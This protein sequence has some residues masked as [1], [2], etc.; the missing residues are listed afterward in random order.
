LTTPPSQPSPRRKHLPWVTQATTMASDTTASGSLVYERR[1]AHV[2]KY[3]WPGNQLNVW[4]LVMLIASSLI[5]GV[6]AT[7]IQIQQQLLLA[8][9]W[10][11]LGPSPSSNPLP[12][13][14]KQL[15]TA[16]PQVL[17]L[18]HNRRR[19]SHRLRPPPPLAHPPEEAAPLHRPHRRLHPLRALG[20][21]PHRRERAPLGPQLRRHERLQPGRVQ[22]EPQGADARDAGV[23][24]AEEHLPELAGCVCVWARGG[25]F[26][27]VDYGHGLSGFC[28]GLRA[29]LEGY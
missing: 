28:G 23:D 14:C 7:F 16:P 12:Y 19:A 22:P 11:V 8:V 10:Y 2:H 20:R 6:F 13:L 25:Y 4:M 3:H 18:L 5:I 1:V 24:G 15:T 21:R 29:C 9:P 26:F 17:L 27:V